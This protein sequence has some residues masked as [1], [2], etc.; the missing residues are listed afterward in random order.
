MI[1]YFCFAF[2]LSFCH[3]RACAVDAEH[4]IGALSYISAVTAPWYSKACVP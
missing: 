3:M 2:G 4:R 1:Q